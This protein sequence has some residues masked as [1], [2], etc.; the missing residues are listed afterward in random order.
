MGV[1]SVGCQKDKSEGLPVLEAVKRE[2]EA[3]AE[4]FSDG[5]SGAR[6]QQFALAGLNLEPKLPTSAECIGVQRRLAS[7]GLGPG[8]E[9]PEV[10]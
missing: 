1:Q 5:S 6:K 7:A 8:T 10:K 3:P 2:G 4:S 9:L